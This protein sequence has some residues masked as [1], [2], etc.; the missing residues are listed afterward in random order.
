MSWR[1]YEGDVVEY[2]QI[3]QGRLDTFD[4]NKISWSSNQ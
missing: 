2:I 4:Q 3:V 1:S